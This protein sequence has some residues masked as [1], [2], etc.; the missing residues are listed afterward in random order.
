MGLSA[1]AAIRENPG[2]AAAS[3][4]CC[5]CLLLP[6]LLLLL[7][8]RRLPF[9]A[10]LRLVTFRTGMTVILLYCCYGFSRCGIRVTLL[11]ALV[12]VARGTAW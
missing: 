3:A 6:V 11:Y 4:C 9:L 10:F 5:Q 8:R 7:F 1:G 2:S 12:R